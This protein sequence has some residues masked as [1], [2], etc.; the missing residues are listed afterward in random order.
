VKALKSK[1]TWPAWLPKKIAKERGAPPT[2]ISTDVAAALS[3][4]PN[5]ST[6][7]SVTFEPAADGQA[8]T[9]RV[10][11]KGNRY[12]REILIPGGGG[13]GSGAK[14]TLAVVTYLERQ[15][16]KSEIAKKR[17]AAEALFFDVTG[18]P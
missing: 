10:T 13:A 18:T 15:S 9:M 12:D 17:R 4:L 16:E 3:Q 5:P 8:W 6:W 2:P 11:F 14:E 1:F 7:K